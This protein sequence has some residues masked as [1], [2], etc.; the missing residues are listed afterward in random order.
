VDGETGAVEFVR[1][2]APTGQGVVEL[3]V[4]PRMT[5]RRARFDRS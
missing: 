5:G 1:N 2:E 4:A 3:M